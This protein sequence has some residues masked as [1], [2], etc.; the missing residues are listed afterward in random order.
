[1]DKIKQLLKGGLLDLHGHMRPVK[2]NA[3]LIIIHIGRILKAPLAGIDRNRNNTV[4]VSGRVIRSSGISH[5]LHAELAFGVAA[6]PRR[7]GSRD[8]L[9][10]LL[11]L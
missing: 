10:I 8:G 1:M 5:I 7:S 2:D 4:S 3:V 6:L 11:R 9:G